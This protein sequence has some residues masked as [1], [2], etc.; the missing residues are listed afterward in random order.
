MATRTVALALLLAAV[1]FVSVSPALGEGTKPEP[2]QG[3]LTKIDG[4]RLTVTSAG[5][6]VVVACDDQT[7]LSREAAPGTAAKFEDLQVGQMLKGY[8]RPADGVALAVVIAGNGTLPKMIAFRGE[9]VSIEG[10]K[11]TITAAGSTT[12]I[13]CGDATKFTQEGGTPGGAKFG[14]VKVGQTVF[15]Y[16]AR[17]DGI[18]KAV[19]I[20]RTAAR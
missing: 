10:S 19:V 16:Y 11:L 9:V 15:G 4:K 5:A 17:A 3:Q 1:G 8:Y 14:D 12:I 6:V 2:I 18:A 20:A 7:K 13:A